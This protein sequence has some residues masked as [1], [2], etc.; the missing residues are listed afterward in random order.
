VSSVECIV[1]CEQSVGMETR[2]GASGLGCEF[3]SVHHWVWAGTEVGTG[4]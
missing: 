4:L 2:L 3:H 1:G